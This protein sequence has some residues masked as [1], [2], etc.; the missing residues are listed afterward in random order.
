MAVNLEGERSSPEMGFITS[1][2]DADK[3]YTL[4]R[5]IKLKQFFQSH[6]FV[7]ELYEFLSYE[8]D[9]NILV[10]GMAIVHYFANT[11]ARVCL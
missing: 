7:V 4:H 2:L 10:V 1:P 9:N 5:F 11:R 6:I 3:C 8:F